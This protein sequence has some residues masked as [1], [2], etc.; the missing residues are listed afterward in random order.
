MPDKSMKRTKADLPILFFKGPEDWEAWL[1]ENHA[2]A[3]GLWIQF[4][5]KESG[6]KS[7]TYPE[8]LDVALCFGWIDGQKASLDEKYWL[9]R[10]TPRRT[11]SKWSE[12]NCK[13][14]AE[15]IAQ[16]K[17]RPAGL[18]EVESAK[19]DGRW[20]QAYKGQR[21][22]SVPEDFA[23]VLAKEPKAAAFFAGLNS[24]N[25]YAI[26]YRIHDAKK[27]ETRARRIQQFL[28]MLKE[29]KKLH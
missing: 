22:M 23:A 21:D 28:Q 17:M 16:A 2:T 20:T 8:A 15:L 5:K 4:A 18:K 3:Q 1:E 12:V 25:R 10:F 11:R 26:L 14:V 6:I 9:Q 13:K 7:L 29:G 24:A 19:K 27:P